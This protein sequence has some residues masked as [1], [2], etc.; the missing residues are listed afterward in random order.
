[1]KPTLVVAGKL[2]SNELVCDLHADTYDGSVRITVNDITFGFIQ[3]TS[4]GTVVFERA[5]IMSS[6]QKVI[7]CDSDKPQTRVV[8]FGFEG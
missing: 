7:A 4:A 8:D 6:E 2:D 1:M 3:R 5:N